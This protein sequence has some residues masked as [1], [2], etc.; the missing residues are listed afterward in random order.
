MDSKLRRTAILSSLAAILVVSLAVFWTNQDTD[1]RPVVSQTY[2]E[3]ESVQSEQQLSAGD[4]WGMFDLKAF[5]QDDSF[6]DP[7]RNQVL[8]AAKDMTNRLSL[9]VTSVEKDLR[10]QIVNNEGLLVEG[11]SFFVE[12]TRCRTRMQKARTKIW[13]KMELFIS[14][15]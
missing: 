3:Q 12:L 11:E 9:V 13:T 15:T 6:F 1:K 2:E 4:Y 8:E 5:E 10:I 7:E 14:V